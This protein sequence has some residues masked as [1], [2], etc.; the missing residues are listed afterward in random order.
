[1]KSK[2]EP[3]VPIQPHTPKSASERVNRII[4]V[5]TVGSNNSNLFYWQSSQNRKSKPKQS[6][7]KRNIPT[8]HSVDIPTKPILITPIMTI[9][10]VRRSHRINS[11]HNRRSPRLASV[12]SAPSSTAHAESHFFVRQSLSEK[13]EAKSSALVFMKLRTRQVAMNKAP[14]IAA[15]R[16]RNNKHSMMMRMPLTPVRAELKTLVQ[17]RSPRF[18]AHALRRSPRIALHCIHW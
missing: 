18:A 13:K 8:F 6:N 2:F 4:L 10:S 14:S 15:R 1:M 7:T 12:S 5:L 16:R 17:R 3:E 9:I 11:R